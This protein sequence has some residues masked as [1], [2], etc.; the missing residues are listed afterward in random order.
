MA[1]RGEE[2]KRVGGGEKNFTMSNTVVTYYVDVP[3]LWSPE[4]QHALI[5]VW[6]RSWEKYGWEATVL[7]ESDVKTHPR[8]AFFDE[9]FNAKPSEYGVPYTKACF[10]RWL[11]AAHFGTLHNTPIL[12]TDY[13]VCSHGF[14]PLEL[15]PN[16]M[17]LFCDSPPEGVFMGMVL[18]SPQHF[19]DM[20]ELF[21]AAAPCSHDWN[22][23]AGLSHQDDL[24][25]LKRMFETGTLAKPEWLVRRG[26]CGLFD[27]RSWQT[28]KAVHY[29]YAMKQAGFWP[30]H[31]FIGKIRPI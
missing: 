24:S 18:G 5:E 1:S 28:S 2:F 6:R 19:L 31:E 25:L 9:I 30:K 23:S 17:T 10:M 15:R 13:D 12:L 14:E 11:A 4:S 16:E 8:F 26:G 21:A 20:T 27:Y 3:G 7:T 29:G 22:Y